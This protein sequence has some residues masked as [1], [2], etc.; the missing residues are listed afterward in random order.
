VPAKTPAATVQKLNRDIKRAAAAGEVAA[1]FADLGMEVR[2]STPEEFSSIVAADIKK[3]A[4]IIK[5]AN[6]TAGAQ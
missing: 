6:V 2:V 1:R 3:W 4:A 5:A